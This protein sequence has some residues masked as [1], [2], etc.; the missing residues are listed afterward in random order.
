[1]SGQPSELRS[2]AL[3]P[4]HQWPPEPPPDGDDP[5]AC[6]HSYRCASAVPSS[7]VARGCCLRRSATGRELFLRRQAPAG[8]ARPWRAF[9]HPGEGQRPAAGSELKMQRMPCSGE[10][11]HQRHCASSSSRSKS[12]RRGREDL[13]GSDWQPDT[14]RPA[15]RHPCHL[16]GARSPSD[17]SPPDLVSRRLGANQT[18]AP[19]RRRASA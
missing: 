1:M 5:S 12:A 16:P 15:P 19:D 6:A 3:S 14:S 10:S 9:H 13:P 7:A 11:T 18:A 17:R 4:V 2:S 8:S